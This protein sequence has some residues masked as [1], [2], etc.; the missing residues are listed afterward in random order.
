MNKDLLSYNYFNDLLPPAG[1]STTMSYKE[2]STSQSP[3]ELQQK[4]QRSLVL[5]LQNLKDDDNVE[6]ENLFER[7]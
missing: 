2:I 1:R 5:K 7:R 4:K 3:I 6:E